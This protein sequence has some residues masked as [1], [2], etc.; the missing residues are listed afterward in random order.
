MIALKYY[1]LQGTILL[2]S[3]RVHVAHAFDGCGFCQGGT[4]SNP[5]ALIA[6][7]DAD[8]IH[9]C[10]EWQRT[11]SLTENLNAEACEFIGPFYEAIC[12]CSNLSQVH[13][14]CD[15][16]GSPKLIFGDPLKG[17]VIPN[18]N[19]QQIL[20]RTIY[21]GTQMGAVPSSDCKVLEGITDYCGGCI[22]GRVE[23]MGIADPTIVPTDDPS[24]APTGEPTVA[25]TTDFDITMAPTMTSTLEALVANANIPNISPAPTT[26]PSAGPTI[27]SSSSPS[28]A[29]TMQHSAGPTITSSSVPSSTP[30]DQPS[31]GPTITSSS[32]PSS[33]PTDQPSTG[34]TI[35]STTM[36]PSS[37]STDITLSNVLEGIT[38]SSEPSVTCDLCPPHGTLAQPSK[39]ISLINVKNQTITKSCGALLWDIRAGREDLDESACSF[40]QPFFGTMCGCSTFTPISDGTDEK[41][42]D[43]I[44]IKNKNC[45]ICKNS[46]HVFQAPYESLPIPGSSTTRITCGGLF[47]AAMSGAVTNSACKSLTSVSKSCGGCGVQNA[48]FYIEPSPKENVKPPPTKENE[49]TT[50]EQVLPSPPERVEPSPPEQVEPPPPP[51]KLVKPQPPKK[52]SFIDGILRGMNDVFS[53]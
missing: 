50:R 39:M 8:E 47:S 40:L 1:L 17:L 35:T 15:L 44:K 10:L 42:K 41:K 12:G 19:N 13:E 4:L 5:M 45:K 31:T 20:C 48:S 49:S 9:S 26:Q 38:R 3:E 7:T 23:E 53:N 32:A 6:L 46:R 34:P 14:Q 16:C 29:P 37:P 52:V 2:L 27:T 51:S 25:S 21:S 11:D 28:S 24:I 18:S 43:K 33:T 22:G 30:T 36:E